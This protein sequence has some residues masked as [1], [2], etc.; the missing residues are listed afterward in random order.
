[1]EDNN[2][3]KN[4]IYLL[5]FD[6]LVFDPSLVSLPLKTG[7]VIFLSDIMSSM[8]PS[9]KHQIHCIAEEC[10]SGHLCLCVCFST[11]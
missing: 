5:H 2:I 1:M 7:F 11:I 10:L 9:T 3:W 8:S 6:V 4:K